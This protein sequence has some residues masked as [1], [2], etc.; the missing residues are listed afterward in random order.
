MTSLVKP[1]RSLN[2]SE[3]DS[4]AASCSPDVDVVLE[5]V[6]ENLKPEDVFDEE[7]LAEWAESNDFAKKE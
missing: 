3:R 4:F 6:G 5:W 1:M 2:P 7:T